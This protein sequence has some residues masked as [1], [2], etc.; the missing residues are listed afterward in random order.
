ML[1]IL[2]IS[3]GYRI[4]GLLHIVAVVVAFGPLFV[5]PTLHRARAAAEMAKLHLYVSLPALVLVWVL[6]MGM[7]GMSDEAIEVSDT[8]VVL[9]LLS[10]V[11]LMAVSW[12]LIRPAITD[13]SDQAAR[14]LAMGTGITHLLLVFSVWLM[15]FKPFLDRG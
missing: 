4:L 3:T 9:A 12:F 5:Y 13:P 14:R 11:V 1:A 10:W 7:I 8:W 6:G 15:V 2:D